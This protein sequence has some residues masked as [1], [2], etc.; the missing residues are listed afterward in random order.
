MPDIDIDVRSIELPRIGTRIEFLNLLGRKQGDAATLNRRMRL[1][2]IQ[3][4]RAVTMLSDV[5]LIIVIVL[6]L[7]ANRAASAYRR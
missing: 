4:D 6:A 5:I 3:N 7:A 1:A 2:V